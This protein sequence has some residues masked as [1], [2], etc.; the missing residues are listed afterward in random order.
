MKYSA[1]KPIGKAVALLM[2]CC[3][4]FTACGTVGGDGSSAGGNSASAVEPPKNIDLSEVAAR[5]AV[6]IPG[7]PSAAGVSVESDD[8]GAIDYSNADNGYVMV[9]YTG[10]APASELDIKVQIISPDQER[11]YIYY[12]KADGEYYAFPL[13]EGNGQYTVG[14][15]RK[16]SSDPNDQRHAV[17]LRIAVTANL[18]S[19]FS[20]FLLPNQKVNYDPDSLAVKLADELSENQSGVV[21]KTKAIYDYIIDNISYD[22]N[23]AANVES[24]GMRTYIPDPEETLR[25]KKGIC[26][27]Y[28]VLMTAML[29]GMD[30]PTKLVFGFAARENADPVYH[31]WILVYSEETGWIDLVEFTGNSWARMDPT[32]AAGGNSKSIQKYIGDGS[33]YTETFLY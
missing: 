9:K 2:A 33:N 27:D 22:E 24:G 5:P 30:I 16:Q 26:Y 20:P 6:A 8:N 11:E 19:E 32:F 21:A 29:R 14:L 1:K 23:K 7:E 18:E 15:F 13:T 17:L 3:F 31:A 25:T 4:F 28:A 10:E 12:L